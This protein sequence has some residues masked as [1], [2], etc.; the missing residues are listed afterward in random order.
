VDRPESILTPGQ[1]VDVY[2]KF[3][4]GPNKK[5]GLSM[6]PPVCLYVRFR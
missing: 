3:A 1:D 2:I 4:D 5:L 6:F